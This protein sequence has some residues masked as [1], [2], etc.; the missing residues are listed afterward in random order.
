MRCPACGYDEDRVIDSRASK[1]RTAI[2]RRRECLSC[3]RRFTTY[4]YVETNALSVV[5]KDGRR[6]AWNREKLLLG[7]LKACEKRPISREQVDH[8]ADEIQ[9]ELMRRNTTE[10]TSQ[11]VGDLVMRELASLDQVAYVRFASVYR[12]FTDVQQF[13]DVIRTLMDA[14]RANTNTE[15][16]RRVRR[17]AVE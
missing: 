11:E 17:R 13:E 2:R 5:K 10:V 16:P 9:S 14:S 4:E 6:E 1:D 3:Q 7:L 12:H 8:V 15:R